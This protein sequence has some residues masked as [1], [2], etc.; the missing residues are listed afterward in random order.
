[1]G[2]IIAVA[3]GKGGTGKTTVTAALSSCLAVLGHKTL[4]IDF[5][6]Q[7]KNLDLALCMTDFAVM[8]F[9][10]VVSGRLDLTA[11]CSESPKIQN[12]FFLSAP[13]GKVPE[14][15]DIS[16]FKAMFSDIRREFDYCLIDCPAGIGPGFRLAHTDADM[17]IIVTTGDFA[18]IR[19]A[20]RTAN[21]VRELGVDNI[22]MIVNRLLPK[23][24]KKIKTNIDDIIDTVGAQL[25]G[26]I[27]EDKYIFAALHDNTPLI[28][29]K[30]RF[31]AYEF[32]DTARRI[33][34]NDVPL[35]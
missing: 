32:L 27:P 15:I 34:G 20:N 14:D 26:L 30:K 3:S 17:S 2:K 12:L 4:C 22:R 13:T 7:L 16:N 18:A 1:M 29:Y 33:A 23:N 31:S 5:D 6:E 9:M 35:R 19:D 11:A 10:D 28:M 21:A 25:V 8:D 24:L